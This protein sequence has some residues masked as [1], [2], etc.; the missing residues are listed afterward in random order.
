MPSI[1]LSQN[2][3][4]FDVNLAYSESSGRLRMYHLCSPLPAGFFCGKWHVRKPCSCVEW[5]TCQ[6]RA[7]PFQ[8]YSAV[9]LS[10]WTDW[11]F[12][13]HLF[14]YYW[15]VHWSWFAWVNALCNLLR[16]KSWEVATP[17]PGRFVRRCCFTLCISMEVERRSSKV[18]LLLHL[19]KLPG[20]G[21][22]EWKKSVFTSFIG[23]SE[24][25]ELME[26]ISFLP[27]YSTSN[28]LLLV[29][30]HILTID[31]QKCL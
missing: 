23:Q 20:K 3:F 30:R 28:K 5:N 29:A 14:P 8:T 11:R 15:V 24:D 25:N 16:R 19:Q 6:T 13:L 2:V 18:P 26:K 12:S 10:T 9:L 27:S 21:D 1:N 31:L 17:L 22:G 7:E 4:S